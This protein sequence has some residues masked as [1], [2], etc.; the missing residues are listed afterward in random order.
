MADQALR[1]LLTERAILAGASSK[2]AER[3][4]GDA[5]AV[6][7]RQAAEQALANALQGGNPWSDGGS[8]LLNP[9]GSAL[10]PDPRS[11]E[12][13]RAGALA[14]MQDSWGLPKSAFEEPTSGDAERAR[15][16]AWG[17]PKGSR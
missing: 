14:E 6:Q 9:D 17:L 11:T 13:I 12:E 3:I 15:R 1:Q 7:E 5:V 8:P 2:D 16:H 10:A 4:A